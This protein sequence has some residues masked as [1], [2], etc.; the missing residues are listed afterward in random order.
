MALRTWI[1]GCALRRSTL[2]DR[3][4]AKGEAGALFEFGGGK[5]R[6]T[7]C[8]PLRKRGVALHYLIRD[9]RLSL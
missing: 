1:A 2:G 7:V 6:P 3:R 5:F 9:F 4:R 8:V